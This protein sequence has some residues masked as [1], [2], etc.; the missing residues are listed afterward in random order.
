[1][2]ADRT[3]LLV[4]DC[5]VDFGS[6]EGEMA[7]RGMDMT[8]PQ[9]ALAKVESL[10]EAARAAGVKVIFVRLLTQPGGDEALCVEG[11]SGADFI[12]PQPQMDEA[13]VSKTRYSAFARTGLA[14]QLQATGVDTV[15][16]A[17]LTTECCVASSAWD[18]F[19]RDF[20]IV[21]ASD[22][23]AA[24]E[25]DLHHHALRALEMSG[26]TIAGSAAVAAGWKKSL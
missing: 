4:I 16:L 7:R 9:A 19:E 3:A 24:Y 17:G 22:A 18:G 26:A 2:T 8:A 14:E 25:P 6:P 5:Q 13:V 15:V 21:I 23:C 20:H 11:T 10:V 1:M 12:G